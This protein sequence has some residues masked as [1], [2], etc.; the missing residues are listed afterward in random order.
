MKKIL[1]RSGISPI[2]NYNPSK[3]IIRNLIGSNVG[4]LIYQ[5][6]IFRTLMNKKV[7]IV[8]DNYSIE[9]HSISDQ[10]IEKINRKYDAYVCPL[11]DAIRGSY[12]GKLDLYVKFI[13]KLDIPFIVA[14]MGLKTDIND[15]GSRKFPFDENVSN[16]I[17]AVVDNGTIIGIRGKTTGNYLS[18]LGF[19]ENK[20]FMVI[21]CP[22]MFSYGTHINI[23]EKEIDKNSSISINSSLM[24]PQSSLK[25]ISEV[26]KEYPNH[27]FIPQWLSEFKLTYL[28]RPDLKVSNEMKRKVYPTKIVSSEYEKNNVRY[29]I[30]AHGWISL[31]KTVNLSFGARLHGNIAATLAGT[32][33]IMVVKDGRM[34][35]VADYHELT[36]ISTQDLE[37]CNSLEEVIESVDFHSTEKNHEKRFKKYLSFWEKNNMKTVYDD[38]FYRKDSPV[39]KKI[40]S[41]SRLP[42]E[43]ITSLSQKDHGKRL[44]E[45]KKERERWK[46][47]KKWIK[48]KNK[49][50]TPQLIKMKTIDLIKSIKR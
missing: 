18:N 10:D 17:S 32:P 5:Y 50:T 13:E 1:I 8:A 26:S 22:S 33:N 35:D 15:D 29:P 42:V 25:F 43:T 44:K 34:K 12:I 48:N 37:N 41:K 40:K 39:D 2:D 24:S 11:A 47:E 6:G 23:Q 21:G 45:Y 28:G 30:N 4:N 31:L 20:D 19:K 49:Y 3:L 7:K 9:R 36:R 27:Y 14:G 16:F 38:D 46:K